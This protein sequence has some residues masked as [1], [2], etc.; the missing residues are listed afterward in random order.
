MANSKYSLVPAFHFKVT[1]EGI[2]A[3]DIDTRFSE[4][5][6][7]SATLNTKELTEAGQNTITYRLP[8]RS[9]FSNLVLKRGLPSDNSSVLS[10]WV[11]DAIY[12]FDFNVFP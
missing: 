9:V 2:G 12:N 8:E 5:S 7:L 10:E 11:K 6:G 3:S 1:F 4:V